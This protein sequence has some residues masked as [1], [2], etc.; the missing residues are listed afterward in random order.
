MAQPRRRSEILI[1]FSFIIGISWTALAP[2]RSADAQSLGAIGGIGGISGET[3]EATPLFTMTGS[4]SFREG[5]GSLSVAYLNARITRSFGDK[6]EDRSGGNI[7][8]EVTSKILVMGYGATDR[9]AVGAVLPFDAT[10]TQFD[11]D[12]NGSIDTKTKA[13]GLG[14]PSFSVKYT[15]VR[16]PNISVR[17]IAKLPTGYEVGVDYPEGDLDLAYSVSLGAVDL[18][19]QAGY[20]YTGEDR[21]K[22]NPTDA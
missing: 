5:E 20:Q 19:L 3:G 2:S 10:R 21:N 17:A 11:S 18:H 15:M 1:I 8:A 4:P 9:W 13:S 6:L 7:S 22:V 16:D 14:N 12:A